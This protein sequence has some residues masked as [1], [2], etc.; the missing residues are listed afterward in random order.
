M[1]R[2]LVALTLLAGTLG[3]TAAAP[4]TSTSTTDVPDPFPLGVCVRVP[5]VDPDPVCA[6]LERADG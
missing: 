4:T 2:W 3:T 5:P 1:R 6:Y